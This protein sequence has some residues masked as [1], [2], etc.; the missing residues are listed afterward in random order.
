MT[1]ANSKEIASQ[2]LRAFQEMSYSDAY[3]LIRQKR[4]DEAQAKYAGVLQNTECRLFDAALNLQITTPHDDLLECMS[5][6][7]GDVSEPEKI[8]AVGFDLSAHTI[9]Q[10]QLGE[11]QQGIEISLYSQDVYDFENATD[12]D[13]TDQCERPANDWQG[14]FL[15]VESLGFSGLGDV[16]SQ[17][18]AYKSADMYNHEGVIETQQGNVIVDPNAIAH[19]LAK[20]L[21]AIEYHRYMAGFVEEVEVPSQMVFIIGEH[22][23]IEVPIVF[24]RVGAIQE[25]E[26]VISP[27]AESSPEPEVIT[28]PIYDASHEEE[29]SKEEPLVDTNEEPEFGSDIGKK[30]YEAA[31]VQSEASLE[32]PLRTQ[33]VVTAKS[34]IGAPIEPKTFG[35]RS[36]KIFKDDFD[37][38]KQSLEEAESG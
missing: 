13:L 11:W 29:T 32:V 36:N 28:P 5:G 34:L 17:L 35:Q 3:S 26:P 10:N 2:N 14:K 31:K 23:E 33:K 38:V 4:F 9:H 30:L 8:K 21:V 12:D 24:Y 37:E 6:M 18:E 22:D 15:E 7:A 1:E 25:M 27:V 20:M 16:V 19:H